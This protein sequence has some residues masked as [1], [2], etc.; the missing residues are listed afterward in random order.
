MKIIDFR[1]RPPYKDFIADG[2]TI[3]NPAFSVPFA[4][5]YGAKIPLS[6]VEKSMELACKEMDENNVV[7]GVVP[8]RVCQG[9]NNRTMAELFSEYPDRFVG[10]AG[11][12]TQYHGSIGVSLDYIDEFILEGP[13]H[14]AF[15]EPG[16][17][18]DGNFGVYK[19]AYFADDEALFPIYE[20]CQANNIPL[21][22]SYGGFTAPDHS[23]NDPVHIDHVAR[24]FPDLH[25]ILAHGC[26]PYAAEACFMAMLR[27][28][29]YLS[30]DLYMINSPGQY[31]YTMGANYRLHDKIIFGTAYPVIELDMAINYYRSIL[32]E[33]VQ[34][35]VFYNNAVRALNLDLV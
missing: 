34:E 10:M 7:R 33:E 29:V 6:A 15:I 9:G 19:G 18:Y 20:K 21:L 16:F 12:P 26:W 5:Q 35:D 3:Y 13:Y 22:V 25:I 31:D 14:G 32:R 23:Y 11:L 4:A 2:Q 1:F 27:K 8:I 30:P 24:E 17:G 28:N